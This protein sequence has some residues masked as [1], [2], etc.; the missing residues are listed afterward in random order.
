MIGLVPNNTQKIMPYATCDTVAL[1]VSALSQTPQLHC[2]C[3]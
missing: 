2:H 3:R 1:L